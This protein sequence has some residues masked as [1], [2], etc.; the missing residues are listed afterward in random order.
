MCFYNIIYCVNTT[1]PPSHRH[2]DCM[3]TGAP[4]YLVHGRLQVHHLS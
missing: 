2:N 4:E 3:A 1:C